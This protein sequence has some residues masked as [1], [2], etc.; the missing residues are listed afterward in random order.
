M[1]TRR[2]L[3]AACGLASFLCFAFAGWRGLVRSGDDSAMGLGWIATAGL[4]AVGAAIIHLRGQAPGAGLGRAGAVVFG[5][6][7]FWA[8]LFAW[9]FLDREAVPLAAAMGAFAA[10][11]TALSF[12]SWWSV[13][14]G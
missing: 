4:A 8:A 12:R 6:V 14:G 11:A 7:A 13:R 1:K 10:V 2:A 3:T 9:I 5:V